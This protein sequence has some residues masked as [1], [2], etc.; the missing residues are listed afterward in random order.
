MKSIWQ[1]LS[2]PEKEEDRAIPDGR[3]ERGVIDFT[4]AIC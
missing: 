4:A 1:Q 2:G 3:K